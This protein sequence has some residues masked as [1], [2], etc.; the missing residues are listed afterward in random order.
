M[1][2]SSLRKRRGWAPTVAGLVAST[3]HSWK[4][5][6]LETHDVA[7]PIQRG[8]GGPPSFF[9]ILVLC[10][11]QVGSP[12]ARARMERLPLLDGGGKTAVVLV[13]AGPGDAAALR[14]LQ[15]QTLSLDGVVSVI[16]VASAAA[17][18]SRLDDL[19]R[20]CGSTTSPDRQAR[21]RDL[22]SRCAAGG[23]LSPGQTD[24][25]S[26]LCAGFGDLARHAFD[27]DGRARLCAAL[28]DVDGRRV[29]AFLTSGPSSPTLT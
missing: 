4:E 19:R 18:P 28:G 9:R 14:A 22:L 13:V 23:P 25:L 15:M 5:T 2:C 7:F 10:A 24:I 11:A 26:G 3:S 27:P 20:Q 1:F 21:G 17:L 29:I 16:P 6:K 12:E 8:H